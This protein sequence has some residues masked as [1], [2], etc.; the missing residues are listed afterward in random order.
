MDWYLEGMTAS[1]ERTLEL[2]LG[3]LGE[4][5][6]QAELYLDNPKDGPTALTERKQTLIK[7]GTLRIT[8][9]RAGGF[10]AVLRKSD[11]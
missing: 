2:P 11:K 9:P 1:E 10:V 8:I 3:F 6:F 4:G 7:T 5:R